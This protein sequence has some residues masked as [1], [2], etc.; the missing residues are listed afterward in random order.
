MGKILKTWSQTFQHART[1]RHVTIVLGMGLDLEHAYSADQSTY[2]LY[3]ILQYFK[4]NCE[5]PVL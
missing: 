3:I 4:F 1:F 5:N 2:V